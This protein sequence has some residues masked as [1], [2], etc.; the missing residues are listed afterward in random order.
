M[1]YRGTLYWTVYQNIVVEANDESTAR[2]MIANNN[3]DE[4]GNVWDLDDKYLL[5]NCLLQEE[6]ESNAIIQ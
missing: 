1:K 6:K 4:V 5:Q 2:R 3:Y